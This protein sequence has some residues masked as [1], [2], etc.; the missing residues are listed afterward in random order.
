MTS[1]VD[2]CNS[3]LNLVGANNITSLT[4]D[5]KAA[6]VCNQRYEFVRDNTFRAH[7]WNCLI[8]RKSLAQDATTPVYKYAYRYTLPTDPYCLRV[9]SV[10]DDGDNERYDVDYQIEAGRYLL[11]DE[12]TMNI[13]YIGRLTDPTEWDIGLVETIAARLASDIAY[14]LIGSSS[15]AQD[16]F[17]MYEMKLK[18]ARHSD[19]TEGYPDAIIADT[20]TAS[21]F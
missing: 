7:P 1:A 11:T 20:Y 10:S 8:T 19:A 12:G 15:F 16:M 3:A 14:P 6:R 13:R 5:S 17:A 4:E 9:L 2:V 18:D 21:R